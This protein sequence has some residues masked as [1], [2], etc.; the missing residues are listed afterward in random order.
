MDSLPCHCNKVDIR[1]QGVVNFFWFP[2][3][4]VRV[5][6]FFFGFLKLMFKDFS[7]L[8]LTLQYFG[9]LMKRGNS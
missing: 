5:V 9:H 6:N 4:Y 2:K 8:M 1:I 7:G 3:T